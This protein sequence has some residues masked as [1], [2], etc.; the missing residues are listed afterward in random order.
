MRADPQQILLITSAST[1][2][3]QPSALG[4]RSATPALSRCLLD[5]KG[6]QKTETEISMKCQ[7]TKA[8]VTF[9]G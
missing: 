7:L 3:T 6:R 1:E 2:A 4:D 9:S 5:S 8:E